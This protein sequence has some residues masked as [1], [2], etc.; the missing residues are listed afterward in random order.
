MERGVNMTQK[1]YAE[2]LME[3]DKNHKI[4][5]C[6]PC[7]HCGT[8]TI[9]HHMAGKCEHCGE[10]VLACSMCDCDIMECSKCPFS[11]NLT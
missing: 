8:E 1:E 5:T 6:E 3:L 10:T 11:H 7:P 9:M 4:E 2:M